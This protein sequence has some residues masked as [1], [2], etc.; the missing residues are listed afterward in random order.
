[1]SDTN[2]ADLEMV[3]GDTKVYDVAFNSED[4]NGVL[5][6]INDPGATYRWTVRDGQRN[7]VFTGTAHQY[8]PGHAWM[9]IN[10]SDTSGLPDHDV[11]LEYDVQVTETGG[12]VTTVQEGSLVV[13]VDMSVLTP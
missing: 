8:V 7:I 1:M 11:G 12:R 2:I 6:P 4:I 9:V 3:R 5:T 13:K 10:P